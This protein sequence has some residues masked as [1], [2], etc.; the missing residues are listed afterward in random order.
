[1]PIRKKNVILQLA[2]SFLIDSPQPS[3]IN[4]WWNLGS[5]LALC[6]VIQLATGIFLA[7]HYSSNLT[8]AFSSVEHIMRDVNY[9]WAIRYAHSNGAS[10]F[11]ACVYLHMAKGL[12]Y[13]SYRSPRIQLWSIGV[14]IFLLMIV[15]AF[16][17]KK[18]TN[19][20]PKLKNINLNNKFKYNSLLNNNITF[21]NNRR[22]YSNYI[23]PQQ[24]NT[25]PKIIFKDIGI[26]V[27][28]YWIDIHNNNIRSKIIS[29]LK[30]KSGI[31]III[32]KISKNCYIGSAI[33]NQFYSRLNRHLLNFYGSKIVKKAVLKD[34]LNNFIFGIL[35]YYDA[36]IENQKEL[37]DLETMYIKA[38]MPKYNILQE[39]GSS[40]GYKHTNENILKMKSLFT[41]ERRELLRKLQYE[42][43]GNWSDES[44]QKL[45]NIA[46]NRPTDYFSKEGLEKI[47]K[48]HSKE[49]MIINFDN[50]YVCKF[51]NYNQAAHYLNTS[52]KTIQRALN[53]GWLYI[54][55]IFINKLND[56]YINNNNDLINNIDNND[57]YYINIRNKLS[58][59]KS[60]LVNQDWNTKFIIKN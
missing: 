55:N 31:Y 1:M 9:G 51:K 5:L 47:S 28:D 6:L 50:K 39:G 18:N 60:G 52:P 20:S 43:K 22:Y 12:Y 38:I 40:I 46:L 32:N 59:K 26:K 2:N 30:N 45:K 7:M 10:F 33:K 35:E 11:F 27:E 48:L 24:D 25:D 41:E 36:T 21:I 19:N 29:K 37:F 3:N 13:G 23:N 57:L 54:P 42:R 17:G 34:G 58:K 4:Y 56:Y 14:I 15:T 53:L 49:I 8:L 44:K 16:M